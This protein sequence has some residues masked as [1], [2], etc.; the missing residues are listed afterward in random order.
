MVL[1]PAT[2]ASTVRNGVESRG[3]PKFAELTDRELDALRHYLRYRARLA[4]RPGGV[5]PPPP[6]AAAPAEEAPPEPP[7]RPP[8]SLESERNPPPR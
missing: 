8:G 1:D 2:F 3:M 7:P 4:T 6:A 5:A